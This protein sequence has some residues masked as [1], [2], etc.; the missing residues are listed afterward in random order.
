V[1]VRPGVRTR[2]QVE[3]VV[4]EAAEKNAIILHT[5]VSD[6]MRSIMVKLSRKY[7]VERIDI[8][9]PL[10]LRLSHHFKD[11]SP[12]EKPGLFHKLQAR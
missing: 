12:S 4:R 7:N 2:D 9:G 10:L 8:M 6:E 5:I 11:A 1:I 3:E